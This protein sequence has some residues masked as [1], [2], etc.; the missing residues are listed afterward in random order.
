MIGVKNGDAIKL[1]FRRSFG[2][3]TAVSFCHEGK[4]DLYVL[5]EITDGGMRVVG[6]TE[7]PVLRVPRMR[8]DG[9]Y[10]AEGYGFDH[11]RYDAVIRSGET[12]FSYASQD[13]GTCRVSVVLPAWNAAPWLPRCLDSILASTVPVEIILVDD[14]SDDDTPAVGQWYDSEYGNV[15]YLRIG[16][17]G[18]SAARNAGLEATGCGWAAYPDS[19]D[20]VH[21]M[22]YGSLLSAA[23]AAGADVALCTY[24]V[25]NGILPRKAIHAGLDG[26]S[27]A[28]YD[29]G[30]MLLTGIDRIHM[31]ACVKLERTELAKE[32]MFAGTE[33]FPGGFVAEEE[34]G[35]SLAVFSRCGKAVAVDF[36]YYTWDR[37]RE[38]SSPTCTTLNRRR[39]S[40]ERWAAHIAMRLYACRKA[41]TRNLDELLYSTC[42]HIAGSAARCAGHP[43]ILG[44]LETAVRTLSEWYDIESNRL[45]R[46]NADLCVFLNAAIGAGLGNGTPAVPVR[47]EIAASRME[48]LARRRAER[49]AWKGGG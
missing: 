36:P 38:A 20:T 22:M 33:W 13:G 44:M 41:G 8:E 27:P 29:V 15:K 42:R 34:V 4:C 30:E 16:H 10:L 23:E 37:R 31:A 49:A 19:D 26:N 17:G 11:G 40:Q 35:H 6:E 45:I 14:G 48:K 28:V 5:Y 1:S 21:P 18:P 43:E 9:T 39:T 46:D 3:C 2:G 24:D 12:S 32:A 25:A 47:P 7:D